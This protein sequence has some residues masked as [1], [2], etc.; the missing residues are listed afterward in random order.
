[1]ATAKTPAPKR[2]RL[3]PTQRLLHGA[4]AAQA[5]HFAHA[6]KQGLE[7]LAE[8]IPDLMRLFARAHD[9]ASRSR[10]VGRGVAF[11]ADGKRY[12]WKINSARCVFLIDPQGQRTLAWGPL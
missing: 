9:L 1:M 10:V 5:Q 12:R 8:N 2:S 4:I 11:N 3:T 6:Q 7:P